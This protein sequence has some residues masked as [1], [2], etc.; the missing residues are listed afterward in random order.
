MTVTTALHCK[1]DRFNCCRQERV[2]WV[3]IWL[4]A[5]PCVCS[6]SPAAELQWHRGELWSICTNCMLHHG[7][8]GGVVGWDWMRLDV[9]RM[10]RTWLSRLL[11]PAR[12]QV[13]RQ[14]QCLA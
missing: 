10:A 2:G 8:E 14:P 13:S 6:A 12:E 3:H 7:G 5:G 4:Q 11:I 9:V 1:H